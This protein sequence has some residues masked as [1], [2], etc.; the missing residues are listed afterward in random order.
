MHQGQQKRTE[1]RNYFQK[2]KGFQELHTASE[3][4]SEPKQGKQWDFQKNVCGLLE[5]KEVNFRTGLR[6]SD[7]LRPPQSQEKRLQRLLVISQYL[8]FPFS[9]VTEIL[10]RANR[11]Y[12]SFLL[13]L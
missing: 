3:F 7:P 11:Y 10:S 1:R 6:L 4:T 12:V 5:E 2:R 13:P 8:A 9:K